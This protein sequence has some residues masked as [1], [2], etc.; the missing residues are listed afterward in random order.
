MSFR[1]YFVGNGYPTRQLLRKAFPGLIA[2]SMRQNSIFPSSEQKNE[3]R[4][5]F[6][7]TEKNGSLFF[8]LRD[9]SFMYVFVL[10]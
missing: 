5:F 7:K 10:F 1:R 9:N 4:N 3:G 6:G 8:P 2:Y